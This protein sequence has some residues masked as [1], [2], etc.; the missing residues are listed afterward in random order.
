[1]KETETVFFIVVGLVIISIIIA[2]NI[3]PLSAGTIEAAKANFTSEA[4]VVI[5]NKAVPPSNTGPLSIDYTPTI[6]TYFYKITVSPE[7][8]LVA[9]ESGSLDVISVINFKRRNARAKTHDGRDSFAISTDEAAAPILV[10][11]LSSDIP[12]IAD[13]GKFY[14]WPLRSYVPIMVRSDTGSV[15]V[16]ADVKTAIDLEKVPDLLERLVIDCTATFT[17]RC[18]ETRISKDMKKCTNEEPKAC[19]Q[20]IDICGGTATIK[21]RGTDCSQNTVDVEEISYSDGKEWK[22]TEEIIISFWKDTECTRR[23]SND[24]LN[25]PAAVCCTKATSCDWLGRYPLAHAL[26]RT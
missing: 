6:S 1:M 4:Q 3:G 18:T 21:I 2:A 16:E 23:A 25:L 26:L 24:L 15:I 13:R 17:L 14:I 10:A 19:E 12:P 8:K 22:P 20:S 7:L 9:R 11:E 5:L